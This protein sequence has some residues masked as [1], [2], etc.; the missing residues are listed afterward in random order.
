[1]W[2]A[3]GGD[4][5]SVGLWHTQRLRDGRGRGCS[6]G[7]E[8]NHSTALINADWPDHPAGLLPMRWSGV[9]DHTMT[10]EVTPHHR[11]LWA[12]D[13][14][15]V[16]VAD[17]KTGVGSYLAVSLQASRHWAPAPIGLAM[18]AMGLAA[19]VAQ[20]PTGALT[21]YVRHKRWMIVAAAAIVAT[22]CLWIVMRP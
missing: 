22:G 16:L 15:N 8:P 14:L 17:V 2:A 1:A 13:W 12:L 9:E 7:G 3:T 18:G 4:G 11:S 21:D 10:Q 19:V 20:M 5:A 6:D